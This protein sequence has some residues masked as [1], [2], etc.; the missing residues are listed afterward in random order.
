[1]AEV[2]SL[3]WIARSASAAADEQES[4]GKPPVNLF[5]PDTDAHKAWARAFYEHV[6]GKHAA[7]A[8]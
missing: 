8:A 5:A 4:T 6:A 2:R 1:M 7:Q 3:E